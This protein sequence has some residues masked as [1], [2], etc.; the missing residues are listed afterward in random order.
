MAAEDNENSGFLVFL[1]TSGNQAYLFATNKL[2][3]NVGASQLT[4]LAGAEWAKQAAEQCGAK[5][6]IKTSGKALLVAPTREVGMEIVAQ[7]TRTALRE[8][9]GL[10]VSGAVVDLSCGQSSALALAHEQFARNHE[11]MG[12]Q[13][14]P[15]LPWSEPCATLGRP[16]AGRAK[17][18]GDEQPCFSA[19]ALAKRAAAPAWSTRIRE[20]FKEKGGKAGA[21]RLFP[22]TDIDTLQRRFEGSQ[23]LGVVFSDGN[24]LGQIFIDL[25]RH[26]KTLRERGESM[27]DLRKTTSDFSKELEC[28]TEEAFYAACDHIHRIGA[29]VERRRHGRAAGN[30]YR[31]PVIPL[32]LGGDDMT[33][34]V[35]GEYALPFARRFLEAFERATADAGRC[36]TL[37]RVAEVALGAPW[38]SACAG[39]ALVKHHFP[40]HLAHA[41]AES[42][43]R[44]AKLVKQKVRPA[45]GQQAPFPVSALDF[46]LMLDPSH[47]DLGTIRAERLTLRRPLCRHAA[48]EARRGRARRPTLDR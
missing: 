21:D 45:G 11:A 6:I 30:D 24:G 44:S 20:L 7:V 27:G 35:Q 48:R 41:L 12:A 4:Y 39:V 37:T 19:E 15:V 40:F 13:R 1:E 25:E 43:L 14:F 42:L 9:P 2:K 34:L 10:Q 16:A 8:A 17:E 22:E 3:E 47:T 38:L 18:G 28:A 23:W 29:S 36:P 32:V 26:L 5:C 31:I 46:H 33:V